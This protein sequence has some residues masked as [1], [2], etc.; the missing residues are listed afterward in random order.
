[1][2]PL[3]LSSAFDLS[4]R[5]AYLHL[6]AADAAQLQRIKPVIMAALPDI[7]ECLY[8][9]ILKQPVLENK[10]ASAQHVASARDAQARHW[11]TLFEGHFDAAYCASVQRI[12]LAHFRIGLTPQWYIGAYTFVL[13][14]LLEQ[15]ARSHARMFSGPGVW[16]QMVACQQAVTKAVNLDMELAISTYWQRM[17]QAETETVD[18]MIDRIDDQLKDTIASVGHITGDLLV[19]A[20]TMAAAGLAVDYNASTA[21]TAAETAL[22][23]AQGVASAAEELHI[24]IAEIASQ[25]NRSSSVARD[26]VARM[27]DARNIVDQLGHAATEI[28]KVVQLIGSIASQTNLLALNATIE[29]ARA[30]DAGKGFAVVAGEVKNLANQSARS[31]EEITGQIAEIQQVTQAAV[32]AIDQVAATISSMEQGASAISAAVEEQTAATREIATRVQEAAHQSRDVHQLMG[33]VAECVA[34][35]NRVSHNVG[36]SAARMD[37]SLTG[38]LKLMTKAVRTSSD[39][40]NRRHQRRRAVLV[41][42]QLEAGGRRE[43]ATLYDLSEFGAKVFTAAPI[44][45]GGHLVVHLPDAGLKFAAVVVASADKFLHLRFEDAE[46]PTATVEALARQ[47]IDRIVELAKSDHVAF[48]EKIA[49]T[50]AGHGAMASG[51]LSTHHTCRLGRWYDSITDDTLSALPAFAQLAGPHRDVHAKGRHV[52]IAL[53]G[54]QLSQAQTRLEELK[55]ASAS[56]LSLLDQLKNATHSGTRSAKAATA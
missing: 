5:L 7:L 30:G 3:P 32:S 35:S 21:A 25:V 1:M 14:A 45:D 28:G 51:D 38:M 46:V 44:R 26:A 19:N 41:D 11:A 42:A 31:A 22:D 47:S 48:V 54:G 49:E 12:G 39:L 6:G 55:V 9:V 23:S 13:S 29:A 27:Q 18:A 15:V 33:A 4:S 56:V 52:L 10:F 20:E 2:S 34:K 37:E 16:R 36:E 43:A 8:T 17:Q 40:A 24:S 50:V 53:E